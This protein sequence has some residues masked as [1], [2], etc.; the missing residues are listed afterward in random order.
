MG[1]VPSSERRRAPHV[2]RVHEAI[3][4]SITGDAGGTVVAGARGTTAAGVSFL[5]FFY[6]SL[7]PTLCLLDAPRFSPAAT[8]RVL[9][10]CSL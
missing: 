2:A 1:V 5:F 4:R 10:E 3:V 7:V 8:S 6:S 9:V